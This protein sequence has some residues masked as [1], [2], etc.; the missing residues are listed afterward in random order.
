MACVLCEGAASRREFGFDWCDA[1]ARQD[2][3]PALV[4]KGHAVEWKTALGRFEAG[5][6]VAGAP[7]AFE[8]V[9][10]PERLL[11]AAVK[12]VV[13][14]VEVGDPLFDDAVFV[15]TSDAERARAVLTEGMQSALLALLGATRPNEIAGNSVRISGPT[16]IVS[17]RPLSGLDDDALL[18]H[19]RATAALALH[20]AGAGG[21]TA[22]P[23][24]LGGA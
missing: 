9:C 10:T 24:R 4:A 2:P 11:H 16:V 1:C 19:Q 18:T 15:R 3:F 12:W 23:D 17:V 21:A 6:G 13:R 20:L 8:L 22:S 7:E 14:E 5:L